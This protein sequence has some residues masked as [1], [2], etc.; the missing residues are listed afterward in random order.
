MKILIF[1]LTLALSLGLT[2]WQFALY[3]QNRE[4]FQQA[5][6]K[7]AALEKETSSLGKELEK[8]R[9]SSQDAEA[10]PEQ[11]KRQTSLSRQIAEQEKTQEA[12]RNSIR[13]SKQQLHLLEREEKDRKSLL[14][15]LYMEMNNKAGS[16]LSGISITLPQ[17]IPTRSPHEI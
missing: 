15:A 17:S 4:Q 8:C 14:E 5:E 10:G 2:G 9:A 16:S 3:R 1:S 13:E 12:L 11:E 7:T 6:R